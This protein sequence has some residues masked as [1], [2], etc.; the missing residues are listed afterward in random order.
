MGQARNTPGKE[1][2]AAT[3]LDLS[4]R[5]MLGKYRLEKK[6][7][8]GG[9]CE[10]WKARDTVE[11]T[12]VA[13][14]IPLANL[15]GRR[16][17][18]TIQRE[19]RLIAQLRH[20]NIMPIKTA[21]IFE[22]HAVLVTELSVGTLDDCSRPMGVRRILF[23]IRQ[24]LEGLAEAHHHRIV[25]CDVTPG[26]IFLFPNNHAAL[27]DF[28]IGLQ[29]KGR[30][31]TIDE[32]GTPGYVAPE[33]AYGKPTFRSDCFS[34]GIILYE[35]LTGI[36]PKWPFEWPF[37][38]HQ[39]LV[40]RTS[41]DFA[42]FIKK[43]LSVNP[44]NRYPNA[45]VMLSAMKDAIPQSLR[46]SLGT[47][48]VHKS[49]DDWKQLRRDSFTRRYARV[50]QVFY[51]CEECGEPVTEQ[52]QICPW[53][54]TDRNRFDDNSQFTH[55]CHHCHKGVL[56]EWSYCP[57][58]YK[59]HFRPQ[60]DEIG[61]M[62]VTYQSRCRHCHGKLMRFMQYCPWCHTRVQSKWQ[63]WPFPD[64]CMKCGWSVDSSYWNYCPWCKQRLMR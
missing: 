51:P 58:C 2:K 57:W 5:G 35:Y 16:D 31:K 13:L 60:E 24:V 50:F 45:S 7:A 40:D 39:R 18:Q 25:H 3:G 59:G 49:R 48:M 28:G 47:T 30:M 10:I 55:I 19:V 17:N 43:S 12:W 32:Y 23:I 11:G 41:R 42:R 37:R 9:Y 15:E 53:C 8:T 62:E 46:H 21:E 52:M 26:N 22:G 4:R 1:P 33:Q 27:G 36:V 14:K 56:P 29:I 34:V 64:V 61:V 54:G 44:K 38:G 6:L 20:P 63:V